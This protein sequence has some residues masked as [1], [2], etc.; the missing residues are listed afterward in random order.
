MKFVFKNNP[1]GAIRKIRTRGILSAI[2]RLM[3]AG[4]GAAALAGCGG[5][6]NAAGESA[7][8][9]LQEQVNRRHFTV[10]VLSDFA[11][12]PDGATLAFTREY[13][14]RLVVG[15]MEADSGRFTQLES[16]D[17]NAHISRPSFSP[18]GETLAYEYSIGGD[19][20]THRLALLDLKTM[21]RRFITEAEG[22]PQFHPD[23]DREP[24]QVARNTSRYCPT[25]SPDGRKL[26][27]TRPLLRLEKPA[28][29]DPVLDAVEFA[30]WSPLMAI[31]IAFAPIAIPFKLLN[32]GEDPVHG[33]KN[34]IR[35]GWEKPAE[36]ADLQ[37]QAGWGKIWEMDFQSGEERMIV[38]YDGRFQGC[39]KY[40][41]DDAVVFSGH[42]YDAPPQ[43]LS[44]NWTYL[45][46]LDNPPPDGE[47]NP[48]IKP[49]DF[50][51]DMDVDRAEWPSPADDGRV[52]VA[53]NEGATRD[54]LALWNGKDAK[55][56]KVSNES[57]VWKYD[58]LAL[59]ANGRNAA[60]RARMFAGPRPDTYWLM[61]V[62][63]RKEREISIPPQN[64]WRVIQIATGE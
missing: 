6:A 7:R 57:G 37:L 49:E 19:P 1:A 10:G 47:M 12:S 58:M 41:G 17:A 35:S 51:S 34:R 59:S 18:D 43:K 28:S 48:L 22:P 21:R 14:T 64:E 36:H 44:G 55:I 23:P 2:V 30:M 56:L 52:L 4:A 25:F 8:E 38:D 62:A 27:Y 54:G 39:F 42:V 46:N 32:P 53:I 15:F 33:P 9:S 45:T 20:A 26:L 63:S 3:L 50:P 40:Y 13:E 29:F 24:G 11:F 5:G 60:Y 31:P 61:N 16:P